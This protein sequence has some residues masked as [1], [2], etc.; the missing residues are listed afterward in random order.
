MAKTK[1][2]VCGAT[3]YA[4]NR[5]GCHYC[6]PKEAKPMSE[7]HY[8]EIKPK[9]CS[10]CGKDYT[11][12][13][14]SNECPH[15]KI[16]VGGQDELLDLVKEIVADFGAEVISQ[17]QRDYPKLTDSATKEI[18]AKAKQHYEQKRMDRPE[19]R[20]CETNPY[21]DAP[22]SACEGIYEAGKEAQLEADRKAL[23][24]TEEG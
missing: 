6:Q 19:L 18:L 4:K 12:I 23:K 21:R 16:D 17:P 20:I 3:G 5:K 22:D 9:H 10:K 13:I 15:D 24:E 8:I 1:C 2:K 11:P 14:H 7:Q